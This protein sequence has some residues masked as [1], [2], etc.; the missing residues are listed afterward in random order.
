MASLLRNAGYSDIPDEAPRKGFVSMGDRRPRIGIWLMPDNR[1]PGMLEDFAAALVPEGDA[2]W[3]VA[4]STVDGLAEDVRRFR[5]VHRAKAVVHTWL[6]WQEEPGTPLGLAIKKR[7]LEP[8][9]PSGHDFVAWV[10]RLRE[11]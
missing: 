9:M 7:Y 10:R 2:L 3:L 5:P 4:N 1:S 8:T 11:A 6:A